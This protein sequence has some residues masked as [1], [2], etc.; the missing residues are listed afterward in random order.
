MTA[1]AK[2]VLGSD[3]EPCG[4]DPLTGFYRDGCCQTGP[5][6]AGAHVVCAVVTEAFLEFS[7]GQGNDLS[8]PQ[9]HFGFAGLRP[10]DR[11]C[12]CAPRWAEALEAGRA[13]D[14]VLEA[15]HARALE[16]ASLADLRDHQAP[17]RGV[18]S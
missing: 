14:V 17:Q 6:D 12:L 5:E 15:T 8:T 3:L 11:W 2:N 18:D 7:R 9:P 16:W 1:V 10:G 4:L 13:P